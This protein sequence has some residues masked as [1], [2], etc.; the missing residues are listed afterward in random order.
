MG[1]F[2]SSIGYLNNQHAHAWDFVD[3]PLAYQAFFGGQHRTDGLQLKWVAPTETYVELT[4]ELGRGNAFPGTDRQGNGFGSASLGARVGGDLGDAASWRVGYSFLHAKSQDRAYEDEDSA[5]TAVINAFSGDSDTHVVDAV[6]KWAPAG[7]RLTTSF[8]LQGE[9]FSR[10]EQGDLT[11]DV[12]G[13]SLGTATG[14]YRSRPSGGYVQGVYQ[15]ARVWRVGLRHDRLSSGTPEIGLVADG[16]LTAADF[17]LLAAYTPRR[18]SAMVDYSLTEFSRLRLQFA[19][20]RAQPGTS[21]RQ[22]FVQYVMSLGAHAAHG[23]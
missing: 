4:G 14:A 19:Q 17:P 5:G 1:R 23:Y 13:A 10:R 2:L 12:D 16:T 3:A 22:V 9:Y 18:T 8:K 15:F 7:N 20:D 21:D 11:Y 6:F